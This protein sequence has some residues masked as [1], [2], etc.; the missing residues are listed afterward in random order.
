[1]SAIVTPLR[2][3]NRVSLLW[4][5]PDR[6][7]E[8][9]ALHAKLFDPPWTQK[10]IEDMLAHPASTSLIAVTGDPKLI[11]GF[12]IG[13]LAAD[14]AEILSIGVV[15]EW[16]RFG[17]GRML[18]EGLI[19]ASRRG[20]AKRLFL[21]VA[22]D[23]EAAAKLYARLGFKEFGRRKA[24]YRRGDGTAADALTLALAL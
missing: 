19:R 12:I 24:Y 5:A 20:E 15:R 4:A 1:M 9:A 13:Q 14:E 7:E 22:E 10:S 16:Q 21:E 6:G 2:N 17:V 11:I 3:L 8:L 23:N 18:L